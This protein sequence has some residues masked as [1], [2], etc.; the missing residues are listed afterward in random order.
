M[1]YLEYQQCTR[2]VMDTTDPD[3]KFDENGCCNHCTE[4]LETTSKKIYQGEKS[5]RALAGLVEK[6]K[7]TGKNNEYD[8]VIGISGGIDS[9]YTAYMTKKIGLRPLAVHL[10]NG[11]DSEEAVSNI[12]KVCRTFERTTK[13]IISRI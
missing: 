2:C 4:F 11:W 8:C 9:C 12:E 5:D 13:R 6:I 10:D 1:K 7:R 3:I